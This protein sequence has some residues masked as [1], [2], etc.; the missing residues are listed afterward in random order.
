MINIILSGAAGRMGQAILNVLPNFKELGLACAV[1]ATG[2]PSVGK[3]VCKKLKLTNNFSCRD[4][5]SKSTVLI[6]F[7]TTDSAIVNLK[8]AANSGIGTVIGVTGFSADQRAEIKAIS[9]TLPIVIS[10][11]MSVG[12]NVMLK[13]IEETAKLMGH[14]YQID[15]VEAHHIHKKDSPSGTAK[16]MMD[17]VAKAGGYSLNKDVFMH[18]EGENDNVIPEVVDGDPKGAIV[19]GR[20]PLKAAVMTAEK[21]KINVKSIREGEIVGDHTIIFT[22]P[23]ERLEITHRA[24]SREVFAMG[25]LRAAMWVVGKKP[26]MYDMGDVLKINI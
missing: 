23:Y 21:K 11:N 15:I 20:S 24:F 1:E 4:E 18:I 12:V 10:P 7:S 6:D 8:K 14:D 16:K 19:S 25:A 2:H 22:S 17:I 3:V 13:I 26:G 9:K 5:L